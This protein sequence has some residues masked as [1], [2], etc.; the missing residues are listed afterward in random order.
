M[1][2]PSGRKSQQTV[3]LQS[4]CARTPLPWRAGEASRVVLRTVDGTKV[5]TDRVKRVRLV[6]KRG[7]R[8]MVD[9]RSASVTHPILS[10]RVVQ[11]KHPGRAGPQLQVRTEGLRETRFHVQW[12]CVLAASKNDEG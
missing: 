10:V 6:T 8:V 1:R 2:C 3:V 5:S 7:V 11:E 12:R 4:T 9:F